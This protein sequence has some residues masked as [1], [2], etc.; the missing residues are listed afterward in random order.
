M[1]KGQ[2]HLVLICVAGV[3]KVGDIDG[4][5]DLWLQA[6]QIAEEAAH[7]STEQEV[8]FVINSGVT[9][10]HRKGTTETA[11]FLPHLLQALNDRCGKAERF[12]FRVS[13]EAQSLQ[14]SLQLFR[15]VILDLNVEYRGDVT[16]FCDQKRRRRVRCLAEF[17]IHEVEFQV[18]PIQFGGPKYKLRNYAM[19]GIELLSAVAYGHFE[20]WREVEDKLRQIKLLLN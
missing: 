2:I 13:E 6:K 3:P 20:E 1:Y 17:F 7:W 16:I 9:S 5:N 15:T 12:L 18:W 8:C 11:V 19:R 4:D 10:R 14:E